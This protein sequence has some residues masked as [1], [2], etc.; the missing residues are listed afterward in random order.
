MRGLFL[1]VLLSVVGSIDV[2]RAEDCV[3]GQRYMQLAKD[4]IGR[5]ENN[6]ALAFLRQAIDACPSYAA[7]LQLGELLALSSERDDK[8]RAVDAFVSAHKL[9][10]SNQTRA[11]ALYRYAELLSNEGDPQNAYPLIKDA[12]T[13]DTANGEIAAL[14]QRIEKDVQ[15]PTQEQLVRGLRDSLYKPL[16]VASVASTALATR[17]IA[18]NVPVAAKPV[19]SGPSINIPINFDTGSTVPD[20]QT[21]PN[22]VKLARALADPSLGDRRFLFIGHADARGDANFNVGLSKQRAEALYQDVILV[23]PSLRGRIEVGGRGASEPIDLGT[24][25]SAYR[26]NR[27]LQV[28][29]KSP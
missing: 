17:S 8:M 27:R 5:S 29:L 2:A 28:L 22:V 26:A 1:V 6:D 11:R 3:L 13:L 21:R 4:S 14:A 20:A 7:H 19:S 10:P 16:L 9:A 24:G 23:E 12:R 18:G 15:N 25:D